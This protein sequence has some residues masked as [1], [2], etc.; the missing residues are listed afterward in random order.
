M[1]LSMLLKAIERTRAAT[2]MAA[3]LTLLCVRRVWFC[4]RT[5]SAR[6]GCLNVPGDGRA[7]AGC[8]EV[9]VDG[10]VCI[11][12]GSAFEVAANALLVVAS[13]LLKVCLA[14]VGTSEVA[15]EDMVGRRGLLL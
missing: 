1:V 4:L 15:V 9:G 14:G 10:A 2:L 13:A 3:D 11:G 5:I 8:C 7:S 12:V 6:R